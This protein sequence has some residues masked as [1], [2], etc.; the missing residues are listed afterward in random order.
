MFPMLPHGRLTR[1]AMILLSLAATASCVAQATKSASDHTD[2]RVDLYGGYGYWHPLNS[3]IDGYQYQDVTNPNATV[4]LTVFFNKYVGLEAEGGYFSGN[5]E[6]AIYNAS[7]VTP[8]NHEQCSQL[9]YTAEGGPVLRLP[10]GSFVPFIHALG[11]GEKVNGPTLQPLFWGW[12]VTGGIGVDYVLSPFH[13]RFALRAQGDWQYSQVVYGPLVLPAGTHGG[14]GEIDAVK[15]SGGLVVRF[16]ESRD[17][18]PVQLGCS[19][20]PLG[21]FPGDPLNINGTT[22][23][24]DPKLKPLYTWSTNGG[25]IVGGGL[26]PTIDTAGMKP[27]EY[28][29]R[30]HLSEGKKARQMADCDAPF[31]IR[32]YEP[33][34]IACSA[35]PG[36]VTSGEDASISTSGGSP[37]NRPLT[38]SYSASAGVV[39]SDGP[40]AKLTTAGL[41]ATTITI[42]CNVVDDLGQSAQSTTQVQVKAV[43][44]PVAAATRPLCGLSFLRDKRRPTRVDNE[45]KGCLD[46]IALA[47]NKETDA[48]LVIVGNYETPEKEEAGAQ[49]T[50]N[51]KQYLVQEK[52][53]DPS[54]IA[55]RIGDASGKT[56]TDTL[57]PSGAL[58][59]DIGTHTFD[60][61]TIVR[62]GPA[63]GI[64]RVA[65]PKKGKR[66]V[67]HAAHAVVPVVAPG[68]APTSVTP[69]A[70]AP[71]AVPAVCPPTTPATVAPAPA[72]AATGAPS[73]TPA[74]ATQV[75]ATPPL[76]TTTPAVVPPPVETPAAAVPPA[77][78][79]APADSP[80][81]PPPSP[82]ETAPATTSAPGTETIP[83]GTPPPAD[84]PPAT[85]VSTPISETFAT[86]PAVPDN[87]PPTAPPPV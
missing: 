13:H 20:A 79:P 67:E 63:Y 28:V 84:T 31:T 76:P 54:R 51:A 22:L 81:I 83:P 85:G 3:G 8:C 62:K 68:V 43:P 1:Y 74:A 71:A 75:T 80:G 18:P 40:T 47:L 2:S 82:T 12:G 4:G 6:H 34:T 32:A 56:A 26:N 52:G 50:L 37:Q 17:K 86:A 23:N 27:G 35:T 49:R 59:N 72:P 21:V 65:A 78:A 45:A 15:M 53:I 66:R 64:A 57:V 10:L 48:N 16:G 77:P 19:V 25:K 60:E 5:A 73:T 38:Y 7:L 14:F 33:P 9:V 44:V 70:S 24:L 29:V 39:T 11:G 87:L 41:S 36:V 42:T 58:F 61:S 30:G 55:L 69:D 46:D